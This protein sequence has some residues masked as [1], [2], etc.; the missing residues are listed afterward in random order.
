MKRGIYFANGYGK[1][2][3]CVVTTV[4]G[5]HWLLNWF[6][7][8][9]VEVKAENKTKIP[10]PF[11]IEWLYMCAGGFNNGSAAILSSLFGRYYDDFCTFRL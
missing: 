1:N 6:T 11:V 4:K 7:G 9:H 5:S 10:M 3:K 2:K 8:H